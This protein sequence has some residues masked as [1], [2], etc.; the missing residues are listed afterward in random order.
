MEKTALYVKQSGHQPQIN[1][2]FH[3]N[4]SILL[5]F[6]NVTGIDT[7]FT[8]WTLAAKGFMMEVRSAAGKTQILSFN[9]DYAVRLSDSGFGCNSAGLSVRVR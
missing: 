4:S 6:Y 7:I 1:V 2:L 8:S 9:A 5:I 3:A